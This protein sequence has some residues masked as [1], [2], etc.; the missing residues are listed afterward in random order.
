MGNATA[1]PHD[2]AVTAANEGGQS[3]GSFL[4][5][6]ASNIGNGG[7]G[8]SASVAQ[9]GYGASQQ[10]SWTSGGTTTTATSSKG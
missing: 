10:E 6:V 3:F 5:S 4:D 9:S 1:T 8:F 7:P 2:A